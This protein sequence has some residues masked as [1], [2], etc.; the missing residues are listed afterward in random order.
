MEMFSPQLASAV[1]MLD[2]LILQMMDGCTKETALKVRETIP[3][4]HPH[5]LQKLHPHIIVPIMGQVSNSKQNNEVKTILLDSAHLVLKEIHISSVSAIREILKQLMIAIF[6]KDAPNMIK[7]NCPEELKLSV[8]NCAFEIFKNMPFDVH[9]TYY[10]KDNI[11]EICQITYT[12]LGLAVCERFRTLRIRSLE[13]ILALMQVPLEG[14][15]KRSPWEREIVADIFQFIL[16]GASSKLMSIVSGD[17]TQGNK[18]LS[19]ALMTLSSMIALVMEDYHRSDSGDTSTIV[20]NL[21]KMAV[22]SLREE[23]SKPVQEPSLQSAANAKRFIELSCGRT[24]EWRSKMALNLIPFLSKIG[25]MR[26]HSDAKVCQTLAYSCFLILSRSPVSLK[27]GLAPLLDALVALSVH[28]NLQVREDS[29]SYIKLLTDIFS[30]HN[31]YDFTQLAEENFYMLLTR[32]PRLVQEEG[33]ARGASSL[34]LLSGYLQLLQQSMRNVLCSSAHLQRL[35][36]SLL[37]VL[38][39][40]CS[41]VN[42]SNEHTMR[43]LIPERCDNLHVPW[44]RLRHNSDSAVLLNIQQLCEIIADRSMGVLDLLWSQLVETLHSVPHFRKESI[45]LLNIL[46]LSASKVGNESTCALGASLLEIY[47]RPDVWPAKDSSSSISTVSRIQQNIAIECLL[48][49][50]ISCCI[51]AMGEKEAQTHLLHILYPLVE[52]AGSANSCISLAG[53]R[54]LT[55]VAL[56]CGYH[57]D[58]IALISGNMD[59]LSHSMSVRLKHIDEQMGVFDA[60]NL[61][62]LHSSPEIAVGM[63]NI[64]VNVLQLSSDK[65]YSH[66][67]AA[68]LRVFLTFALGVRQ[69]LQPICGGQGAI[70]EISEEKLSQLNLPIAKFGS[71]SKR[72]RAIQRLKEYCHNLKLLN[73]EV[74]DEE[75]EKCRDACEELPPDLQ[76]HMMINDKEDNS[77]HSNEDKV[78]K[79]PELGELLVLVMKRCLNFLPC[80]VTEHQFLAMRTLE[81]GLKALEPYTD[82]LL[83]IVHLIWAPLVGR[84]EANQPPL[85]IRTAFQLLLTMAKTAKEFLMARCIREVFP[86]AANFLKCCINES[87]L[88]DSASAYRFS[89]KYKTQL[90]LLSGLGLLSCHLQVRGQDFYC[91][92][93]V[94]LLYLSCFQ[95]RPLQ[96][97]AISLIQCLQ[98]LDEDAVWWALVSWWAPPELA[99]SLELSYPSTHQD[100][101]ENVKILLGLQVVNNE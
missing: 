64:V 10:V 3:K 100:C 42:V 82:T 70:A 90:S 88:K 39:L 101:E 21:Q 98:S 55:R 15:D 6:D 69:W 30:D 40:D 79:L 66:N 71:S 49:E 86:Q 81:E 38:T 35:T 56:M 11:P 25:E 52:K 4:I 48:T 75:S 22:E 73:Y 14:P 27:E 53:R 96:K 89:Q 32:L 7:M 43:E 44:T 26:E 83:P 80:H 63:Q 2:P 58:I 85:I 54:A 29:L 1:K 37:H 20:A 99:G 62:L 92:L 91:L 51:Y 65:T 97:A 93:S 9:D 94:S 47:M 46:L 57:S 33:N 45:L 8:M 76:P 36:L 12:C 67:N 28:E 60:L 34:N 78:K 23:G 95:P 18:L 17:I 50:G 5:V 84:F 31:G 77:S 87:Y 24:I 59:Y 41:A 16:P 19:I 13:V 74:S 68:H 61:I 72:W